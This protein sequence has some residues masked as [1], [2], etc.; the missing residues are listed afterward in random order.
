M[1]RFH[2]VELEDLSWFPSVLRQAG[3][4][5]LRFAARVSGQAEQ[6]R[7][8]ILR[9]LERSGEKEILDLCSGGGGPL[10]AV[11]GEM[12]AAGDP[13]RVTLSDRFPDPGGQQVVRE[14]GLD[15]VRYETEPVDAFEVSAERPGLRTLFNGFHHFRPA[16]AERVL[17]ATVEARKP[18]A[19]IEVL[20]RRLLTVVGLLFSPIIVLCVVPFLRPFRLAWIPFTYVIPIIPL[21]VLWDGVMSSLRIYDEDELLAMAGAA[22]PDDTF[23]WSV[24]SIE[25]KPAPVPGIAF[26]GIP[27]ERLGDAARG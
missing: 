1:R 13:V 10:L 8:V 9:A 23:E 6:I 22:D 17:A 19:V 15:T 27:R 21:F 16:E 2:G 24:E 4:A 25:M 5:Y 20:Q 18:I 3:M 14:S 12:E 26:V 11:V 7:P